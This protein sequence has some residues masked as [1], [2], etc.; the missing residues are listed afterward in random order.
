[1]PGIRFGRHYCVL[2]CILRE[3]Y[4]PESVRV[5]ATTAGQPSRTLGKRGVHCEDR[6]S[7]RFEIRTDRASSTPTDPIN[8]VIHRGG[9]FGLATPTAAANVST[10]TL[11]VTGSCSAGEAL[12]LVTLTGAARRS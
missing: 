11:C 2:T 7:L 6:R 9:S 3:S 10:N 5:A 8:D 12:C 4:G 1:M